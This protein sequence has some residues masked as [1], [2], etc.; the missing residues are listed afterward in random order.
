MSRIR[1]EHPEAREELRAAAN[2]YDDEQPGLGTDFYDAVDDALRRI[3]ERPA[4]AAI[5]PGWQGTLEVRSMHVRRF[6]YRVLYYITETTIVILAYSNE[7]RR[8][9][10][11]Q[12]R[13]HS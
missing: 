4:S 11:W 1:R 6:P 7:H 2:W 13:L 8:P 3:L 9:G 5:F 10:Y 12:D